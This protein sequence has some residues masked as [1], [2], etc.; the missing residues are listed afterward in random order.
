MKTSYITPA[1]EFISGGIYE[2]SK[3]I[4]LEKNEEYN[5]NIYTSG[6]YILKINGQYICEGPCKGH[7]FVRYYDSVATDALVSGENEITITVMHTTGKNL[8][9]VFGERTPMVIFEAVSETNRIATDDTWECYQDNRYRLSTANWRKF[10]QPFEIVDFSG[11]KE[12]LKIECRGEFDFEKGKESD[13][14]ISWSRQLEKRPIPMLYPDEEISFSVVKQGDGFIELD[15]GKYTTAKLEFVLKKNSDVKIIYAECYEK[16]D[17]KFV[18]DDASGFLKGGEGGFF[19]EVKTG[20]CDVTFSPF[21]FRAFRFIR[22]EAE[23]VSEVLK[24]IK[25]NFWHYPVD[26]EGDF[27][28]SDEIYNKMYETSINTML[29]CT[30]ETFYDCP[31]FE[32][33]QYVMDSAIEIAVLARLTSDMRMAKKCIEEFAASQQDTGHI[34]ANYPSTYKQ[35]IPGFSLFWIF[36]LSDYLDWSKDVGFV[37]KFIG[38]VEK[39]LDCFRQK[40]SPEGLVVCGR[41]WDYADWV[42]EWDNGEPV[43]EEGKPITLYTMYYACGLLLASDIC[44]KIGRFGLAD[45][46]KKRHELVKE[47]VKKYCYDEQAGLYC[48]SYKGSGKSMHTIIW[49]VLSEVETDDNA[50]RLMDRID[51]AGL[52]KSSFS[53]NYYLFRAFEKCGKIEEIYAHFDGWKKMLDMHCTSWCEHPNNPRSE[54]HG[55]SSAPLYEFSAN[56]LGVKVGFTDEI[57]IA[58]TVPKHLEFAKGKVPT[59][60]GVIEVSWTNT[61]DNF[62][63]KVKAP[64]GVVKKLVLPD[65]EEKCFGAETTEF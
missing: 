56:V 9:T 15:A 31:Y 59:R 6:R 40:L 65:G 25:G 29:C 34:L 32:Q 10:I 49:A 11:A 58:P 4:I 27:V 43:T 7:E 52:A 51:D 24:G 42:P 20:D 64:A 44:K 37:Q 47:S 2:F 22:I 21:W 12:D 46:Y 57:V 5:I 62:D 50:L 8:T 39:I 28:C 16:E 63:I 48:D 19:D 36:M 17:G 61:G 30:H 1:A 3:K 35:V 55:W 53:M 41:D 38:N 45:E 54:C 33:Q 14:G 26:F 23:N 18:R 13:C 60:F